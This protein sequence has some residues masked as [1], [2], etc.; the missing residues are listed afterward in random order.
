MFDRIRAL[1]HRL[2][3][4]REVSALTDRDLHDLGLSREQ[5]LQFLEMP[6]DISDRVT[7]MGAIFGVPLAD[8]KRDHAQWIDLLTTCGHCADRAACS[9]VLGSA[10]PQPADCGFCG[11]RQS[12]ADLALQPH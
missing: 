9:Q 2:N 5:V 4:V 8:L 1:L 10:H 6:D 11:N 7:A 3:E 12:F